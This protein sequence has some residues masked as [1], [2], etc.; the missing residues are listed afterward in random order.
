MRKMIHSKF[1]TIKKYIIPKNN[2][3]LYLSIAISTILPLIIV[4]LFSS[5]ILG[6]IPVYSDLIAGSTTW[7]GYNKLGDLMLFSIY[8][9]SYLF[10]LVLTPLALNLVLK[11]DDNPKVIVGKRYDNPQLFLMGLAT[12]GIT[13]FVLTKTLP[14]K[15]VM[16]FVFFSLLYYLLKKQ[17]ELDVSKI[18]A[19]LGM[20]SLFAC[21]NLIVINIVLDIVFKDVSSFFKVNY[22]YMFVAIMIAVILVARLILIGKIKECVIDQWLMLMQ[23]LLPALFL[24]FYKFRYTYRE[25]TIYQYYSLKLK[26]VCLLV[27]TLMILYNVC[28]YFL[29]RTKTNGGSRVI[30]LT[31]MVS[32]GAFFAYRLP[33]ESLITDYYHYG[34]MTVP[35]QQL[36]EYGSLPLFDYTPAH[37]GLIFDYFRNFVNYLFFNGEYATISAA[38]TV[39]QIIWAIIACIV[40]SKFVKGEVFPFIVAILYANAMGGFYD[41]WFAVFIMLVILYSE[42]LHKNPLKLLWW[43]VV[44]SIFA[45]AWYPTIGGC[46]AVSFIP[47]VIY[48]FVHKDNTELSATLKDKLYRRKLVLTWIPVIIVGLLFIPF[49]IKMLEFIKMNLPS[50]LEANGTSAT[51]S[52]LNGAIEIFGDQIADVG[53]TLIIL[54]LGFT[55]VI[56]ILLISSYKDKKVKFAFM[57]IVLQI[58]LLV[59]LSS[60]YMFG[61]TDGNFSRAIAAVTSISIATIGAIGAYVIKSSKINIAIM[62]FVVV[63]ITFHGNMGEL[64]E[65]HTKVYAQYEI[66]SE[67]EKF[68]GKAAGIKNLGTIY[69]SQEEINFIADAHHVVKD[70]EEFLDLSDRVAYHAIFGKKNPVPFYD[71]Y[72]TLNHEMQVKYLDAVEKNPTEIILIYP[73]IVHDSG[74]AAFRAYPIYKYLVKQGYEPYKHNGVVFLLSQS[75]AKRELYEKADGEFADIMHLEN[76]E[77]LPILWGSKEIIENRIIP[78]DSNLKIVSQSQISEDDGVKSI[79]GNDGYISYELEEPLSGID[80]DF[81]K[82]S[83]SSDYDLT[84]ENEFRI[85]WADSKGTFSDEKSFV[86]KGRN[87]ELLIPMGTSPYWSFSNDIKFIRFDFPA[88]MAGKQ[89]PDIQIEI[90]EYSD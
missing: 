65:Q 21:F 45:I 35:F 75:S 50:N 23:I 82:V 89:L 71:I 7:S 68:D 83:L 81:I 79:T 69:A 8:F 39:S 58:L 40:I 6:E 36:V 76:I 46:A 15:M 90:C 60:N 33:V 77:H 49:F 56:A 88:S 24:A 44:A 25:E 57:N 61:R 43:W 28:V 73:N 3:V 12:V 48:S 59:M 80:N 9:V 34:E 4:Y 66:N 42:K 17:T 1:K 37:G 72:M 52:A 11:K 16:V 51:Y 62:L 63:G 53:F 10:L 26:Y 87:G 38:M 55:L 5:K 20:L 2:T 54:P 64:L 74:T 31:S 32:L 78:S 84:K 29:K 13:T 14:L 85:Y 19:K 41:R 27:A 67:F 47:M 22:N 86:F 70:N 18:F 30:Q